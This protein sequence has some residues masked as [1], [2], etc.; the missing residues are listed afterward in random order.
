MA[1]I[2]TLKTFTPKN[3]PTIS[4]E[5]SKLTNRKGENLYLVSFLDAMQNQEITLGRYRSITSANEGFD[6]HKKAAQ[7]GELYA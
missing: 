3:H 2:K 6:L 4:V 1:T 5:L 7:W